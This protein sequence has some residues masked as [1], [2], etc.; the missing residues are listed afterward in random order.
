MASLFL[1]ASEVVA[2]KENY[3]QFSLDAVN[4]EEEILKL[5]SSEIETQFYRL[6]SHD[7][8]VTIFFSL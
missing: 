1:S 3:A 5:G 7:T 2:F 6:S 4:T 8:S